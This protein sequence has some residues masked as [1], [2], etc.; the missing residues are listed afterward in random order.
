MENDYQLRLKNLNYEEKVKD[1]SE[2]FVQESEA[3]KAKI[4]VLYKCICMYMYSFLT[5]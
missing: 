4:E 1:L 3:L 2:K 5:L